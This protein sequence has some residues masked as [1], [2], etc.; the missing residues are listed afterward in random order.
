MLVIVEWT[1]PRIVPAGM[2][3]FNARLRDKVYNIYFGFDLI[4]D[5]HEQDY[6]L[7]W[8]RWQM[9]RKS[10]RR[11][12]TAPLIKNKMGSRETAHAER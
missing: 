7:D 1:K 5:G 10:W 11:L 6:R 2:A 4:N 3:K 9:K 12:W 8:M